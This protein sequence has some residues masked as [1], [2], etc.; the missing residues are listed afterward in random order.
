MHSNAAQKIARE[1]TEVIWFVARGAV[2]KGPY[3]TDQLQDHIKRKDV[4][5]LDF[6]WRQGFREWRPISSV[7]EFDRRADIQALPSYPSVEVPSAGTLPNPRESSSEASPVAQRVE[8]RFARSK[9]ASISVYEWAGA[10]VFGVLFAYVATVFALNEVRRGLREQMALVSMG[11]SV[12]EGEVDQAV[13][14][15]HLSPLFSAPGYAS[16]A[17]N[18]ESRDMILLSTQISGFRN[19]KDQ[20]L[21]GPRGLNI[22]EAPAGILPMNDF[23][24]V[25]VDPVYVRPVR[26]QGV[27]APLKPATFEVRFPGEPYRTSGSSF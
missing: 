21:R 5:H 13:A 9:R 26:L 19:G 18:T 10:V 23:D 8:V 1:A 24:D 2:L 4:S 20:K 6:C 12:R 14:I 16:M 25:S 27:L 7:D 15:D 11:S 17:A 3:T 22:V